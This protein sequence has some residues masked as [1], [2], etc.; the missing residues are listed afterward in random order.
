MTWAETV[1]FINLIR[2]GYLWG[3]VPAEVF[4][5]QRT[6]PQAKR[7]KMKTHNY[8]CRI[9]VDRLAAAQ[10]RLQDL[11]LA[12]QK[13][14]Q[15]KENPGSCGQGMIRRTDKYYAQK[16]GLEPERAPSPVPPLPV[17]PP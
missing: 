4:A 1:L 12:A 16:H 11:D 10:A 2:G 5:T 9:T 8:R 6:M 7:D 14:R 15:Q 17:F 3:S 13:R